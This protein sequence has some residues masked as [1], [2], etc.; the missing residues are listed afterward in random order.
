[1]SHPALPASTRDPAWSVAMRADDLWE[2]EML[3]LQVDGADV[4]LIRLGPDEIH[5][6]DNRCPHA[7]AR[8][9]NGHL[10]ADKG[11]LLCASHLWEFDART[12]RGINPRV[13][14]LHRYPVKVEHGDVLVQL[15][16]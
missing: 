12:G 5:A 10:M 13:C 15:Q 3:G 4:L 7:G 1:M 8:L 9:S 14:S 11:K 6:Y 16:T 2:G